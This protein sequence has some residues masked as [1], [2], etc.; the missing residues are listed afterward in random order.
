MRIN[1]QF[2]KVTASVRSATSEVGAV[3]GRAGMWTKP[4]AL[5]SFG[6]IL[7]VEHGAIFKRRLR[8]RPGIEN[9]RVMLVR[10]VDTAAAAQHHPTHD[11]RAA[12]QSVGT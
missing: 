7:P 1:R 3:L 12:R 10:N 5:V 9:P 8:T 4:V 11:N 6:A 2:S